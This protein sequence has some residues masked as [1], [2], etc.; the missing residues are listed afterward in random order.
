MNRSIAK[1][2]AMPTGDAVSPKA[3]SGTGAKPLLGSQAK[4]DQQALLNASIQ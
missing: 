1:M 3:K 2:S 4:S